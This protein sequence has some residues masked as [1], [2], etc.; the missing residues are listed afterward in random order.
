[1]AGAFRLVDAMI[2]MPSPPRKQAR[3]LDPNIA[4]WF[5]ASKEM[6]EGATLDDM[7]R[8]MDAGNVEFAHLTAAIMGRVANPTYG[9]GQDIPDP[10]FDALCR[11]AAEL[12]QR[13]T[14]RFKSC[15][16]LDPTRVM[17]AVRRLEKA[18]REH[19]FT[20]AYIM[21][22]TSQSTPNAWSSV[23]QSRSTSACRVRCVP[24]CCSIRC[25]WTR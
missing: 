3:K 12:T 6:S 24:R 23:C 2:G 9:V 7:V 25:C 18:V 21:P 11:R 16:G 19:G 22:A 5:K 13:F 20:G 17:G 10:L 15:I 8:D 4:R 1:M 14:G